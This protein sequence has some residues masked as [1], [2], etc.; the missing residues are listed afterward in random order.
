MVVERLYGLAIST[1]LQRYIIHFHHWCQSRLD[2]NVARVQHYTVHAIDLLGWG[3]ST[4]N[5]Y[6]GSDA[7][8]A[9]SYFVD[10]LESWR[11]AMGIEKMTLLGHSFGGKHPG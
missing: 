8:Q 4:R 6:C 5:R 10:S 3:R 11:Q 9:Q 1:N 7:V 2:I